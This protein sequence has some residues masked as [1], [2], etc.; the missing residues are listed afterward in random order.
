MNRPNILHI[1]AD[2]WHADMVGILNPEVITPNIDRIAREGI[3]LVNH[4]TQNP[5]CT[6]ARVCF[7]SGQ[8]CH[9]HGYYAFG[10]PTPSF[11]CYFH[12]FKRYGYRTAAIGATSS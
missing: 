11:P 12:H 1:V 2:Q 4:Y 8:Y 5:I 6:P 9:N 10:G 3:I 7:H